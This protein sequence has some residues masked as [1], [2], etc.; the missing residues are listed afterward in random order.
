MEWV[1]AR[2]GA[3]HVKDL[4]LNRILN[5][6]FEGFEGFLLF[7]FPKGGPLMV[8][9]GSAQR[10]E[11]SL[12]LFAPRFAILLQRREEITERLRDVGV[13]RAQVFPDEN[14]RGEEPLH[15]L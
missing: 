14:G 12:T 9:S 15:V 6:A 8:W 13:A 7:F 5:Q 4:E 1:V 10:S 3:F 11:L 2:A